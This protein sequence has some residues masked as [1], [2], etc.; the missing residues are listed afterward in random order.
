[1]VA[2]PVLDVPRPPRRFRAAPRRN[3]AIAR[4]LALLAG[5]RTLDEDLL[6]ELS[7]KS[8]SDTCYT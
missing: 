2:D 6:A 3:A 4:P 7:R 1:M 8:L 5:V